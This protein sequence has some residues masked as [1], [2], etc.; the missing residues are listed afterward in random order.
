MTA[1]IGLLVPSSNVVTL[2]RRGVQQRPGVARPTTS[3]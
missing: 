1:R 2:L 3:G